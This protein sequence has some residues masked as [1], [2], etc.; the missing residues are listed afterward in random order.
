MSVKNKAIFLD[1]DGTINEDNGYVFRTKDFI[2]AI[3]VPEAIRIMNEAGYKVI[4]VS[5]QSGIARNYYNISDV[6]KL[7][8]YVD[9]ELSKFDA[10]IDAYYI[11]PHHPNID[12]SC[13]CRKPNPGLILQ[14]ANDF[15]IDIASSWM[16]GDKISDI[17][18]GLKAGVKTAL[19]LTGYGEE[20]FRKN[21]NV[22]AFRNL[23]DFAN[24]LY[25]FNAQN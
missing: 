7:H 21:I 20:T 14:G 25:N 24:S 9:T 11:C 22:L 1:R 10:Y 8:Q 6:Q 4:V 18:C 2:F 3:G 15:N 12:V 19:V 5:N 16:I 23:L 13:E 17:E